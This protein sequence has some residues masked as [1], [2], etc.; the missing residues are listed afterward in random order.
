MY[1][2]LRAFSR[3]DNNN[4]ANSLTVNLVN[5][6]VWFIQTVTGLYDHTML[7]FSNYIQC[8]AKTVLRTNV[9][10]LSVL[11]CAKPQ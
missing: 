8:F 5:D 2:T 4:A 9:H 11:F 1:L 3:Q 6:A 10:F 7:N